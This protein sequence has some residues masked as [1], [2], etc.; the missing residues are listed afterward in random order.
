MKSAPKFPSH[1][2]ECSNVRCEQQHFTAHDTKDPL[3]Q[4]WVGTENSSFVSS[5]RQG[6]R[7]PACPDQCEYSRTCTLFVEPSWAALSV[8]AHDG[9]LASVTAVTSF[10]LSKW[11]SEMRAAIAALLFFSLLCCALCCC[12]RCLAAA[13]VPVLL[14]LLLCCCF[15]CFR[16]CLAVFA[17]LVLLLL[18]CYCFAAAFCAVLLLL[19]LCCCFCC[20]V[21][22]SAAVFASLLLLFAVAF[23]S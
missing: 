9:F 10:S 22:C 13:F 11:V 4:P 17:T 5:C 16:C 7:K 14:L 2:T 8:P 6:F 12:F 19:L 3:R 15:C 1:I 23:A 20:C 21:C 18:L